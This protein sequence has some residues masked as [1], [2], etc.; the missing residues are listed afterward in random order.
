MPGVSEGACASQIGKIRDDGQYIVHN[1]NEDIV[2]APAKEITKGFLYDRPYEKQENNF[3]IKQMYKILKEANLN[4]S[5]E[6]VEL[7]SKESLKFLQ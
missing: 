6:I 3:A 2:D 1:A 5:N 4:S 7:K